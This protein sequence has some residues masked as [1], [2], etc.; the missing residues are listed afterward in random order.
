MPCTCL[1]LV[2]VTL[3]STGPALGGE[4]TIRAGSLTYCGPAKLA[5]S[6]LAGIIKVLSEEGSIQSVG[7]RALEVKEMGRAL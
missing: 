3:V 2:Q 7:S 1:E 5:I 4:W 6:S